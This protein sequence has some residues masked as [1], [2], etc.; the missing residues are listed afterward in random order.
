MNRK[1]IDT[2]ATYEA[3]IA[4][5]EFYT[6]EALVNGPLVIEQDGTGQFWKIIEIND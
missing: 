1:T 4:G 5:A 6:R 3:A 2:D